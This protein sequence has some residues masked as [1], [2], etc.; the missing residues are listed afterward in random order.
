[1]YAIN[2]EAFRNHVMTAVRLIGGPTKTSNA[3]GVSN[4]TVHSWIKRRVVSNI[5]YA[6]KLAELSGIELLKLRPVV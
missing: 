3:L 5:D 2:L 6:K 4:A 1:M